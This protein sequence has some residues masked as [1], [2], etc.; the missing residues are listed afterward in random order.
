MFV[1]ELSYKVPLEQVDANFVAHQA[2]LD[3]GYQAGVFL[4]SGPRPNR[5]GGVILIDLD[6]QVACEKWLREDPFYYNDVAEYRL[7]PFWV[8]RRA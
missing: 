8:T 3:R 4:A 5:V 2:F 7:L 1:A 6:D